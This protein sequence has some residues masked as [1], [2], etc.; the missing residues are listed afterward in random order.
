MIPTRKR[1]EDEYVVKKKEEE[2][3]WKS[4]QGL[5]CPCFTGTLTTKA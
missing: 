5:K 1:N 4:S 3:P 2:K